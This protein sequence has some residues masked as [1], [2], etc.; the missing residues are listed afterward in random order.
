MVKCKCCGKEMKG[1]HPNKKFCSNRG[2]GN[3]KDAFHNRKPS[4][5]YR[6]EIFGIPYNRRRDDWDD[7]IEYGHIFASGWDGHG[8]E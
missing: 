5:S 4:R 6:T 2:R 8:Q 3:C 7:E 1:A